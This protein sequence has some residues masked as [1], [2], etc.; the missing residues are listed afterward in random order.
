MLNP[1]GDELDELHRRALGDPKALLLFRAYLQAL[2]KRDDLSRRQEDVA[3][4]EDV[5]RSAHEELSRVLLSS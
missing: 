4:A 2:N 5:L 1:T 3:A